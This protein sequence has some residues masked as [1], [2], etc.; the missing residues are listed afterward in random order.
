MTVS[1]GRASRASV[2]IAVAL[3]LA[4]AATARA[5]AANQH[6]GKKTDAQ[7]ATQRTASD[8]LHEVI[9]RGI[10]GSI[11]N[12]LLAQKNSDELIEVVSSED[13]GKLPDPS[14]AESLARL[15]AVMAERGGDGFSDRISIR[16]LSSQFVGTLVNGNVQATT[17]EN[18]GVSFNQ[19]PAALVS[20]ATVYLTPNAELIGQGLSGTIDLHTI[21]P[22]AYGKRSLTLAAHGQYLSHGSLNHGVGVGRAGDRVSATYVD[23]FW[24]H[25]LGLAVGVEHSDTPIQE[26]TYQ[27]W[28]WS[29]D[30]GPGSANANW[31]APFT[32]GM[33][34]GALAQEGMQLRAKSEMWTRDALLAI[35]DWAPSSDYQSKLDLFYSTV[36]KTRYL[37]GL[38]WSS[39]PWDGISYANV[40][41]TPGSPYPLAASGTISGLKPIMQN[42][43]THTRYNLMSVSWNNKF[44]LA[45]RWQATAKFAYSRATESLQDAYAFTGLAPGQTLSTQFN[46]GTGWGFPS[47]TPGTSLANSANVVFTDPDN[48]GYNGRSEFDNQ[49]DRIYAVRLDM[50]HP[51]GWIFDDVRFGLYYGDRRKTKNATVNF[52]FLN[53]NGSASGSYLNTF[54]APISS[55][56]LMS[57]TSLAYGGINGIVNYN[58]L[59][60]LGS[61]F[62][63]V[64]SNEQGDWSR[65]Y[66]VQLKTPTA[67]LMFDID[68]KLFG[69]PLRGNVGA[70]LVH[71]EQSSQALQT[72]GNA[73]AGS[74]TGGATY[75]TF[76][77][78][79]NLVAHLPDQNYLRLGIAKEMVYGLI[80]D[81][82]AS[83]SASVGRVTSG[84]AAGQAVWSGSGG[85][86]G[87]RPY[88][89]DAIDL[90]WTKYFGRATYLQLDGFDKKLLNYIYDQT[91][92]NYNFSGYTNNNPSLTASSVFGSFS[93]PQNG[94]G[95][96]IYGGTVSAGVQFGKLT[97]WLRGVGVQG[98]VTRVNSNIPKS[99][100]SQI[101]GA[102]QSLP[103]LSR[104]S[105]SLTLYYERGG[106][107]ARLAEIYR[108]AYTGSAVALFDQIGYTRVL[109]Y[110]EADLQLD[111]AFHRGAVKGLT[112][113]FDVSNLTNAPYRTEQVSGLPNGV[114]VTMPLE[115]DTWGRTFSFGF[116]YAFW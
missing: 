91:V 82:R 35:L 34:A 86:P 21:N 56:A 70:Q 105:G 12:S 68:T 73:V 64:P 46:L 87:L 80:D 2:S 45:D 51:L 103:G 65:N 81:L 76:L 108:S 44:K 48:Y 94:T 92:L 66:S 55:G 36:G 11:E 112:V 41:T 60:A 22:L 116:R 40:A 71:T 77:P 106:F 20:G 54:S 98:N 97:H 39:S 109:A 62:Y 1:T 63:M 52:A 93:Q 57:P 100:I 10:V 104:T 96:K 115:Y 43:Y 16:G 26:Q 18:W 32:P 30:N 95:G 47:F 9:V 67:Y 42:E 58:V 23:Q 85:N 74:L 15:P 53:G 25:T 107:S 111:Y 88:L 110:K 84:P 113:L 24:H 89:A 4:C 8:T 75:N 79:M 61:Q 102:P 59:S 78:S 33:P 31:G 17:G 50:M 27:N 72:T 7:N 37:N 3:A 19:I 69:V 28:W 5:Q 49:V 99:T 101:P 83:A 114:S 29:I 13:I 38:Q 90:S 14:I 6:Q